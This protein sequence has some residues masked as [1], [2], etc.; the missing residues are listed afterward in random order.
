MGCDIQCMLHVIWNVAEEMDSNSAVMV[1]NIYMYGL[2]KKMRSELRYPSG[3]QARE[4]PSQH[5]VERQ[6]NPQPAEDGA[7]PGAPV[8]T[9]KYP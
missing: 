4:L 6:E 5:V 1:C 9:S 2:G 8:S 7:L 3:M